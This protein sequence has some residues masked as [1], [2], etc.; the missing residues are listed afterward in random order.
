MTPKELIQKINHLRFE[1]G[2]WETHWQ[3]VGDYI[4]PTKNNITKTRTPGEK[5][6]QYLLDNTAVQANILLGGFLHGL[7]TNPHS[8]FFELT[9]GID[10]LD[11]RDD[12]RK[13]LQKT[14]RRILHVLN[15]S[16]F[17]TEIHE[18]YLD[19]GSFGTSIMSIEEDNEYVVRFSTRPIRGTFI[20][21]DS[22]GR[23]VEVY[24]EFEWTV[25]QIIN[26]FGEEVLNKSKDLQDS[27][28]RMDNKKFKVV[29]SVYPSNVDPRKMGA[30]PYKSSY[31]L[32]EFE[33]LLSEGGFRTFPYVTPRW[34]KHAGEKYGRSPSMIAL[35]E[36]KSLNLMV[37][38][39]IKGAQKVV[40]PPLE[41]PDDGFI[42]TIRTRPGSLNFKRPGADPI[43]PI[44]NDSRIDFGFQVIED[45]RQRIR[46]AYFVDQL[47]LR[48]GTPQM[49]ATEVEA[50]IDEALRFMGPVLAR[51]Q[52][53]LLRPLIDRVYEIMEQRGLIDPVPAVFEQYGIKNIDVQYSSMIARMQKQAEAKSI[54]KTI[55]QASPFISADPS[56]LDHINGDKALRVLARINNFPQEILRDER[57]VKS[58]RESRAE[59]EALVMQETLKSNTAEN[60]SKVAPALP[61]VVG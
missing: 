14:S 43:R 42:G 55:E 24:R 17:Q 11:D 30:K 5:V 49:T 41:V 33:A 8:Q 16:N 28:R 51:Q 21:E 6:N 26:H 46:D 59:Q 3:E 29:H 37:E 61:K 36:V 52:S 48:Q 7:L 1:R 23:V 19:L 20:E 9:T 38:T 25:D 54:L 34:V 18:L 32:I 27:K 56:I 40:D 12:V 15:N 13:W 58:L 60:I 45:K 57:E 31:V 39:T 2:T 22:K 10:E 44:F 50:R 53:E 35:P 47:K 4:V